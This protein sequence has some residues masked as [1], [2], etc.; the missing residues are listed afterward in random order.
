M[1]VP[2]VGRHRLSSSGKLWF[3]PSSV[4]TSVSSSP[5]MRRL[6]RCLCRE[7]SCGV[8]QGDALS[9]LL[10]ATA[11]TLVLDKHTTPAGP[12]A[13][14]AYMDDMVLSS[15]APDMMQLYEQVKNG[16][17]RLGLQVRPQKTV[18][19]ASQGRRGCAGYIAQQMGCELRTT[20]LLICGQLLA[21]D[22]CDACSV[23]QGRL[24]LRVPA[25]ARQGPQ[26]TN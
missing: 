15:T 2:G 23:G 12:R 17:A 20:G 21:S 16:L 8:A 14:C 4:A 19:L 25:A 9:S 11:L 13:A 10:F 3:K 6:K 1:D 22:N 18:L 24:C 7:P 5:A 26:C